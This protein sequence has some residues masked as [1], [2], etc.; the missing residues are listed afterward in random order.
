MGLI[1]S[2]GKDYD[3]IR[4]AL[5]VNNDKD[6]LLTDDVIDAWSHLPAAELEA[7]QRFT[8]PKDPN[9]TLYVLLA[10]DPK[11]WDL[12]ALKAGVV[13]RCCANLCPRMEVTIPQ[14]QNVA[15]FGEVT[16]QKINWLEKQQ[17]FLNDANMFWTYISSVLHPVPFPTL[18]TRASPGR[19]M[20]SDPLFWELFGLGPVSDFSGYTSP[21]GVA[22]MFSYS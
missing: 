9:N 8:P 6:R 18:L 21:S 7:R 3:S 12:I 5:G 2:Q 19:V 4:Y 20:K 15:T 16:R 13:A 17:K 1:L 10:R 22:Y 11:D 14:A